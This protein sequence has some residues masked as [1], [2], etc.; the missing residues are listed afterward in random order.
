MEIL[1]QDPDTVRAIGPWTPHFG[2]RPRPRLAAERSDHFQTSVQRS[3]FN[4]SNASQ[5][6]HYLSFGV[7]FLFQSCLLSSCV[8]DQLLLNFYLPHRLLS[9]LRFSQWVPGVY[10]IHR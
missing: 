8:I 3:T 10:N 5:R 9:L 2:Q 4:I 7:K 6:I 1:R